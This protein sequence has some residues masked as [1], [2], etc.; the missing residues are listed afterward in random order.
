MR[1]IE[2]PV[3]RERKMRKIQ[4]KAVPGNE[5]ER[6]SGYGA[7]VLVLYEAQF[8]GLSLRFERCIQ[9]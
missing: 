3:Y 6:D 7:L 4:R 2:K 5:A 1:F 9:K 8:H